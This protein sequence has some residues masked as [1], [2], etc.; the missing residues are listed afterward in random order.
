MALASLQEPGTQ[1]AA[2]PAA[3]PPSAPAE[4]VTPV[5]GQQG[6]STIGAAQ[7]EPPATAGPQTP[8]AT[9]G[10]NGSQLS[11]APTNDRYRSKVDL[12]FKDKITGKS[13]RTMLV[14]SSAK[15]DRPVEEDQI[16]LSSPDLPTEGSVLATPLQ[17][18]TVELETNQPDDAKVILEKWSEGFN[19]K[20]LFPTNSDVGGQVAKDA[21]WQAFAAIIASCIGIILYVWIRFQNVAFGVAG[22]VALIHD[23]LVTLAVIALTHYVA[24]YLGF[25][26]IEPFKINLS[27]I[28]A[29]L[30]IIGYSINDTIVIFDRLREIRGKRP[31]LTSDMVNTAV[32]QTLSRTFLTAGT[33]FAVV[34]ILYL[35]G[36]DTVHGF[37]FAMCV[38]VIVG[39]YSSVFIAAPIAVWM[40]NK[41]GFDPNAVEQTAPAKS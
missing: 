25:A 18:W 7:T 13:I 27:M 40:I 34:F 3:T 38:G 36:G 21:Q 5:A 11:A 35:L 1:P 41:L 39:T 33:T 22:V 29:L 2:P 16:R 17:R 26:M 10:N 20:A 37:A 32:S 14:E 4:P 28:A 23:V 9:I 24:G 31:E 30:T 12:N 8:G 15:L 6:L 19:Q